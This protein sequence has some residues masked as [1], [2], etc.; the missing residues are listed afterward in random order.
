MSIAAILLLAVGLA[1]DAAAVSASRGMMVAR[2]RPRHFVSVA[3]FFG[4]SQAVMPLVGWALGA[5]VGERVKAWDHWIAF[6]L[7]GGLGAKMLWEARGGTDE[8]EE[9]PPGNPFGL[10]IMALLAIATSLDALAVGI[11]LPLLHAPMLLSIAT[12]GVVT[13]VLSMAALWAGRR[14]GDA[15]GARLEVAGG[16]VLIGIGTKIL[17]EHL[18]AG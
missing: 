1:A 11:T 16:L 15:L 10:R 3:L 17:I 4:V 14:F 13:A 18:I 2:L 12:I 8:A 5:A 9:A 7:L 6:V